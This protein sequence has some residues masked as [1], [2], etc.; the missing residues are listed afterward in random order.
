MLPHQ[1]TDNYDESCQVLFGV[2][3]SSSE[4]M[5]AKRKQLFERMQQRN[6]EMK[7]KRSQDN[8]ENPALFWKEFNALVDS[9]KTANELQLFLN[10]HIHYLPNYDVRKADEKIK[11]LQEEAKK[12]KKV[13]SFKKK[14]LGSVDSTPTSTTLTPTLTPT[15]S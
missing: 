15:T 10:N 7:S 13:F 5:E 6:E 8:K 11:K 4:M 1:Q 12:E 14:S 9:Q 2:S 3:S